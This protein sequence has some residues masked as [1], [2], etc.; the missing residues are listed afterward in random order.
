MQLPDLGA[1]PWRR[2]WQAGTYCGLS[3]QFAVGEG[4]WYQSAEVWQLAQSKAFQARNVT[5]DFFR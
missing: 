4:Q 1:L 2:G 3:Q 5:R